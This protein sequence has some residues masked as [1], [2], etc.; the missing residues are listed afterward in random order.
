MKRSGTGTARR[1]GRSLLRPPELSAR[2]SR[3]L[4]L[5]LLL[6]AALVGAVWLLTALL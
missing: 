1:K 4:T 2:A 6:G 3:A 5:G